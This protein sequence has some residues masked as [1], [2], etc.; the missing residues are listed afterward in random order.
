MVG[1]SGR[2]GWTAQRAHDETSPGSVIEV[3]C[4]KPGQSRWRFTAGPIDRSESDSLA[5]KKDG[6]L[7]ELTERGRF[8]N[9]GDI[10]RRFLA[11]TREAG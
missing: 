2:G 7:A 4:N 3:E 8:R 1:T 9:N 10:F 6:D 11:G 5:D